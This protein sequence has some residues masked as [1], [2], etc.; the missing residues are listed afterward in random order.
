MAYTVE[1]WP[2]AAALLQ[3]PG[4]DAQGSPMNEAN[5]W[6]RPGDLSKERLASNQGRQQATG[7]V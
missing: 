4:T 3:F 6:V 7:T 5:A 1:N 2:I